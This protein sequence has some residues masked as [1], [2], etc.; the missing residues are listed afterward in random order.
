MC[1]VLWYE[2][3]AGGPWLQAQVVSCLHHKST[4]F[5]YCVFWWSSRIVFYSL[6]QS[7][8]CP[9]WKGQ[10]NLN[11]KCSISDSDHVMWPQDQIWL[12]QTLIQS[13]VELYN[14][15]PFSDVFLCLW[16][17]TLLALCGYDQMGERVMDTVVGED[18]SCWWYGSWPTLQRLLFL[19]VGI[20]P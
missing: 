16:K 14:V 12:I 19:V 20:K 17:S 3:W 1:E 15:W 13:A 10:K 4:V 9:S 5:W 7:V 8:S 6:H 18:R 2:S 11:V